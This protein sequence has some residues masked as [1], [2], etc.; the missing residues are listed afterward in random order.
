MADETCLAS[1]SPKE[2]INRRYWFG[3]I[4]IYSLAVVLIGWSIGILFAIGMSFDFMW[5]PGEAGNPP[6]HWPKEISSL[7]LSDKPLVLVFLHPQCPCSRATLD[8][9]ALAMEHAKDRFQYV[10]V[11]EHPEGRDDDWIKSGLWKRAEKIAGLTPVI[12]VDGKL[13]NTFHARTSGDTV[14]YSPDGALL[15]HGGLTPGRDHRGSNAGR[16]FL[17]SW[18]ETSLEKPVTSPVFGCPLCA[19]PPLKT[20]SPQEESNR[21]AP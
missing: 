5:R 14:V 17:E 12:D 10:A 15:F 16:T 2:A 3:R 13:V 8:E 21:H 18:T 11:F 4:G 1:D 19:A 20:S 7:Q 9:L 6:A